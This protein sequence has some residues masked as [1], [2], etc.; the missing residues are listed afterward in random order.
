MAP[1]KYRIQRNLTTFNFKTLFIEELGWDILREAAL[2]IPI[3]G[4][5]HMLRPLVEKR[6]F[7]VYLCSPDAHGHLPNSAIS[8]FA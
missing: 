7:K 3:D 6:S 8:Q 5:T 2:A 4:Q 1:D